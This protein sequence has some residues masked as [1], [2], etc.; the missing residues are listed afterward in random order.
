MDVKCTLY[1]VHCTVY[2][3]R[4]IEQTL[5]YIF[6]AMYLFEHSPLIILICDKTREFTRIDKYSRTLK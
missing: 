3:R 2:T 4:I 5:H 6:L 1:T